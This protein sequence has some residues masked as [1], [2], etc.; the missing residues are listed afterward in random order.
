MNNENILKDIFEDGGSKRVIFAVYAF[1]LLLLSYHALIFF[2]VDAEKILTRNELQEY[3]VSFTEEGISTND[4]RVISDDVSEQMEYVI[5]ETQFENFNGI[6][7]LQIVIS[8]QET[9]GIFGGPC[10]TV[11]VNIPPNGADAD[12]QNPT[13]ILSGTSDN[14]DDI[15]LFVA[16]FPNYNNSEQIVSGVE[17]NTIIEQWSSDV[18]GTGV[19]TLTVDVDTN[20]AAPPPSPQDDDEEISVSWIAKY[21]NVNVEGV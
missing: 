18:H 13:N 4:S 10:D 14:C 21:F 3:S 2:V 19:F 7:Y 11:S 12:W 5:D 16:I 8:Y 9:G 17:P 20:S 6:G 1:V 15:N